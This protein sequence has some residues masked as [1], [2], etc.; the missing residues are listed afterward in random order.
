MKKKLEDSKKD[1]EDELRSYGKKVTTLGKYSYYETDSQKFVK[2]LVSIA[3]IKS[4][5]KENIEVRI[6]QRTL[7]IIV[8]EWQNAETLHFGV[9][10]LHCKCIPEQS[11]W[12]V[13]NDG[14]Q[15]TL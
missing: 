2:C 9:R 7:D 1:I 10:K 11:K 6:T 4:H 12:E 13:K 5:P 14:I 3:G 8:R 15:V